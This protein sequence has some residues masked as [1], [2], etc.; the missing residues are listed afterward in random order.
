MRVD[1]LLDIWLSHLVLAMLDSVSVA[2]TEHGCG[3][4]KSRVSQQL[5]SEGGEQGAASI[6]EEVIKSRTTASQP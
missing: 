2:T 3:P 1:A 4:R 6:L 5:P